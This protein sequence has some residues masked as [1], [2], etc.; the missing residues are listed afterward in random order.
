VAVVGAVRTS[1]STGPH[2]NGFAALLAQESY[3]PATVRGKR[4]PRRPTWETAGQDGLL[5][6]GVCRVLFVLVMARPVAQECEGLLPTFFPKL[7]DEMAA[8]VEL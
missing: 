4:L 5:I 3:A 1:R 6:R 7:V 2:M 8:A